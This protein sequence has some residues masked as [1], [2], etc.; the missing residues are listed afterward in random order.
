MRKVFAGLFSSLDGV[1]GG[2]NEW[3]PSFDEEMGPPGQ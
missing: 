3:Q 1:V 2:P